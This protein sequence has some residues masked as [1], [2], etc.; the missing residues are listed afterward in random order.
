MYREGMLYKFKF[1]I[2]Q[3][4]IGYNLDV[5]FVFKCINA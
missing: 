2:E 5:I 1:I 4:K 3:L